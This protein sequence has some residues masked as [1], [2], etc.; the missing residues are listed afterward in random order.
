M[1]D[2]LAKRRIMAM[3]VLAL[4]LLASVALPQPRTR[5]EITAAHASLLL[6]A[7]PL[8]IQASIREV[9]ALS[10]GGVPQ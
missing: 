9:V 3:L 8:R 6:E 7:G 2:D 10:I 4:V 1:R 5:L